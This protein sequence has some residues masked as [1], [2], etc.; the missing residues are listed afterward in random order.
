[1]TN[2]FSIVP[3]AAGVGVGRRISALSAVPARAVS[4]TG[5]GSVVLSE[6]RFA[7]LQAVSE[8]K[9]KLQKR[10]IPGFFIPYLPSVIGSL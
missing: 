4:K 10:I 1:M 2:G 3:G 8:N 5:T 6:A 7:V 9:I